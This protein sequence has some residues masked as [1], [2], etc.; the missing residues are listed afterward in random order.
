MKEPPRIGLWRRMLTS[1]ESKVTLHQKYPI[2]HTTWRPFYSPLPLYPKDDLLYLSFVRLF[3][4]SNIG[5]NTYLMCSTFVR[6]SFTVGLNS[7]LSG[8]YVSCTPSLS[9]VSFV[10]VT[11][12]SLPQTKRRRVSC[13]ESL[14]LY[15][16]SSL[17][18][19]TLLQPLNPSSV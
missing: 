13:V 7:W 6:D 9:F 10:L 14:F 11:E 15:M 8:Q 17:S 5:H 2:H 16:I 1:V 19:H 4:L 3:V 12:V 18:C